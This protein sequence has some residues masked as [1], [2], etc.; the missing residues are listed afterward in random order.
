MGARAAAR[1]SA[2][3]RLGAI[4]SR[5]SK[6]VT[7]RMSETISLGAGVPPFLQSPSIMG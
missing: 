6:P 3:D 4:S 7:F 1:A 5:V 2:T